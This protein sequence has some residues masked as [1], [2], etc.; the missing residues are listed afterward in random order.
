MLHDGE[1]K[2]TD[3]TMTIE[4]IYKNDTLKVDFTR[5]GAEDF[6][7]MGRGFNWINERPYNR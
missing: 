7:L 3:S 2:Y 4:G 5:R 6:I 1:Y